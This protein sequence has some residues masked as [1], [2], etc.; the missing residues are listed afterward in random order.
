MKTKLLVLAF[1]FS[2]IAEAQITKAEVFTT[3]TKLSFYPNQCGNTIPEAAGKLTF[4]DKI[5]NL[6]VVERSYGLNDRAVDCMLPNY[7]NNDEVYVTNNGLSIRNTDGTWENVP[8]IAIPPSTPN[9]TYIPTIQ[10]G[11]VLPDGKVIIQ[12][13]NASYGINIYDRVLKTMT[14]VNFPNN[15]YPYL[16]AYDSDR[17]LTWIIAY[18]GGANGRYLYAY[19]GTNLTAIQ[20]LVVAG[21]VS[22]SLSAS[23][24]IYKNDH[25]YLG[26]N[27]GLFKI[28]I[29]DYI[30]PNITTTE[31][32]STTT[33]GLPFDSVN[34]LQFDTNGDLWLAQTVANSDGGIVKFNIT[35][36]TY[37]LYQLEHLTTPGLN[38]A[39][40]NIALDENNTIW[41]NASYYSG[42]MELTFN[43]N[44][45]NWDLLSSTDLET[46]GVPITYNPN[47]IYFRNN[48]FYFTTTDFSSGSNNNF[49]VII[50]NDDSWSGRNDN[51]EGNLS[52]RMNRRFTNNMPDANGGV[53]WFNAYDDIVVHRDADDNHQSVLL[54]NMTFAAV[55]DVDNKA[56]VRGGNPNELRK[57]DFPNA[58]SIQVNYNESN[59]MK[60]V[61]DQVWVFDRGNKK[62]DAYKNDVL[63][64]T[65]NLDED[66]YLNAFYFAVD[67]N[68]DTWF[69][70]NTSG[71]EIKKFNTTTLTSTTYDLSSIGSLSTLRKVVAAPNGGVWFVGALGAVYQENG[72]FY[73]FLNADYSEL[74][75]LVDIVVDINGKAY[76]LNNDSASI[77]TIENPTDANPILTNIS[78][79]NENTVLPSLNHYRPDA[80]T[81]DSE[82]SIWTH[83]SL[84]A[85][86]LIDGDLASEYIPQPQTLN[87]SNELLS[88]DVS[89]YPNPTD[90]VIYINTNLLTDSIEVYSILGHKIS[91]FKNIN[92]LDLKAYV[93][94]LYI[95]K[96][97]IGERTINKKFV[98]K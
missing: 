9:Y 33:P 62:I 49:E 86:K 73:P 43:G 38:Y 31:Y 14:K 50:N 20:E 23:T 95:M 90:G 26:S 6:G 63:V 44:T 77:T 48:Q 7:F 67:D 66:W 71:I 72:V 8:N 13:T 78:I 91:E 94:G 22:I 76:L 56:I 37:D 54:E 41:T 24:L 35:N 84:N 32:N 25:L 92:T 52:E 55:V 58:N 46:L 75:Y 16:F 79:E 98:I 70:R 3:G 21:N 53:W 88:L 69:V 97:N 82:G 61:L 40:Q 11:L 57:I 29:T 27:N 34:D 19:D 74:Y 36:E 96:I 5:N 2:I 47:N 59:D 39:F 64:H 12:A 85:F 87:V 51:E 10:N 42:I 1:L 65:Y 83:A 30:T 68:G 18:G 60:R 17:S 80:L 15:R 28:N 4:C 81:I 45:P 89:I 93:S